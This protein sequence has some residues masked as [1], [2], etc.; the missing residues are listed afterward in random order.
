MKNARE[1]LQ[2]IKGSHKKERQKPLRLNEKLLNRDL[3]PKFVWTIEVLVRKK[4]LTIYVY[5]ASWEA[6]YL[7]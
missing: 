3:V 2:K 5:K 1:R 7:I 6:G 4:S